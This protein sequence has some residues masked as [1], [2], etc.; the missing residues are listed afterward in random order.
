MTI[1]KPVSQAVLNLRLDLDQA[2][3]GL[4][5]DEIFA[6][7]INYQRQVKAIVDKHPDADIFELMSLTPVGD[8]N[9][10]FRPPLPRRIL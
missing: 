1:E 2:F 4:T 5:V 10:K 8:P 6:D 9:F 7:P 3:K